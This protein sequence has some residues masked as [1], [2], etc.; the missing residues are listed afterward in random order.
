MGRRVLLVDDEAD[1][2]GI[3]SEYLGAVGFEVTALDSGRAAR[4]AIVTGSQ[5]FDVAVI[6]WG[7]PDISGRDVVL[8]LDRC[9]PGCPILVTTGHGVDVVGDQ[10][11]GAQVSAVLRKPFTMQGLRSRIEALL[12]HRGD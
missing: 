5:P 12:A 4:D 3:L 11:V 1:V 10:I 9:Q 2:L 6:D 8:A 7:L